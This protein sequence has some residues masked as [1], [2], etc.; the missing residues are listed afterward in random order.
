ME[1][2]RHHDRY[3]RPVPSGA[4]PSASCCHGRD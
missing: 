4:A 1:W 2:V 3:E